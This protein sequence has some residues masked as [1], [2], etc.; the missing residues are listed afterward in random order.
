MKLLLL[1]DIHANLT[2]FDAVMAHSEKTYGTRLSVVH[3]GDLIDYGMRPNETMERFS[4]LNMRLI[5]NLAG[6][7]ERAVL[8]LDIE[9]FSSARNAAACEFTRQILDRKWLDYFLTVMSQAAFSMEISDRR[10][11]FV[12]G[13]YG[14]PFWG[15]MPD[16]EMAKEVYREFDFVISG[17]THVPVL[18]EWFYPD[19]SADA[20]RAKKKTVFLNPGSVGQPRNHNPAAQYGVLDIQTGSVH[21]NA[22]PYDIQKEVVLYKGEVDPFYGERL[23][24]G[25]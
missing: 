9:R 19:E 13:D 20:R 3:L 8:G 22:V 1:S 23:T 14:D 16:G 18:K 6:N 2:A 10:I 5:V 11:L 7:H 25:V 12:H 4:M 15:R 24:I 21:F 17:H